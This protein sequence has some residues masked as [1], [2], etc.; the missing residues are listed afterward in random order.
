[1]PSSITEPS[2]KAVTD[3]FIANYQ[4]AYNGE[5]P[6]A[7]AG[8]AFE[9]ITLLASAIER[10]GSTEPAALQAALNS[11]QDFAGPDGIY[12]YSATD[13]DGLTPDDMI[14][15]RVEGGTWVLVE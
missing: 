4:A 12:N 3:G 13:R 14:I 5:S 2:Q 15:V 10:A 1:M 9:A 7:F 11:T 6:N 8:Y